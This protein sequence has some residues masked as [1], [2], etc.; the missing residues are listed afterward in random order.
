MA[1]HKPVFGLKPLTIPVKLTGDIESTDYREPS[2]S[3]LGVK[4]VYTA[5]DKGAKV[6]SIRIKATDN[7]NLGLLLVFITNPHVSGDDNLYLYAEI[8]ISSEGP[9]GTNPATEVL[10]VFED[11]Q[12]QAGQSLLVGMKSQANNINV[13]ASIADFLEEI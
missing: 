6:T 7:T 3:D 8:E 11:F 10:E 2:S 4:S 5:G 12:L 13:I 9:D 1:N